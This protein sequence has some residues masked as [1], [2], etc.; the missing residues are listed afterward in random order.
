[1]LLVS[2]IFD[3]AKKIFGHCRE[4]KLFRQITD[5]IELLATA[6]EIDPLI[7]E[8]DICVDGNCVTLPREVETPLAVNICGR[9]AHGEDR[10]FKYHINGPGTRGCSCNWT[11]ADLGTFPTYKDLKCPAKLIAFLDDER[12]AGKLLRVFGYDN[13]NRPLQT[14]VGDIVES[15]LRVPM[16]FGYSLPSSTDPMVARITGIVKDPT[17]GNVRLS[18][19]DSST[20]TGTLIGV[21][22]PDETKPEYRRI[23][24]SPS[25]SWVSLVYRKR[26]YEITSINDRILIHSRP[27][28]LLAMRAFKWYDDGDLANGNAYEANAVRLLTQ[29]QWCLDTPMGAPLQVDDRNSISDKNDYLD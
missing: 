5:S 21:F 25:G 22:E 19:F 27:A 28:M 18:S 24:I 7:G 13:Q 10:L 9:P 17:L 1:M 14:K 20:S 2:E 26:T 12:D 29:K 23:R 15:G 3:E 6:G 16:I 4:S 11:W 8:V